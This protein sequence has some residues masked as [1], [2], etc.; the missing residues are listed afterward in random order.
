VTALATFGWCALGVAVL[1]LV[2]WLA[3]IRLRDVS[4]IDPFWGFGFV[5]VAWISGL[6]A[7]GD[8]GR[9]ALLV[10]LTSI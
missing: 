9:R 3:S 1:M 10:V 2:F 8:P 5:V 4:I 6:S 7:P